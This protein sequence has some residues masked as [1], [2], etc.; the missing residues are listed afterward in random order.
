MYLY[1]YTRQLS[2]EYCCHAWAC[3]PSYYLELLD[4]LQ[5]QIYKTVGPSLAACLESLDH[6]QDVASSSLFY[7]CYFSKSSFEQAEL[8]PL[9]Y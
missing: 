1:K 3:A 6:H 2:M 8:V 9:P 4:K 7:S 5:K